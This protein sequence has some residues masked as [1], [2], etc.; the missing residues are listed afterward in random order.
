MGNPVSH[1]VRAVGDLILS[2]CYNA[3]SLDFESNKS[4]VNRLIGYEQTL[5]P[6]NP[7]PV[8]RPEIQYDIKRLRNKLAGYITHEYN[9]LQKEEKMQFGP[10]S[11]SGSH[12]RPKSS[13]KKRKVNKATFKRKPVQLGLLERLLLSRQQYR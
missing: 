7:S 11:S 9:K 12:A 1:H 3:L 4:L 10:Y 8:Y 5:D 13:K 2:K 6:A